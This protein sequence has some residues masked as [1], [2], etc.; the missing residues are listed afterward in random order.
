MARRYMLFPALLLAVLSA[1]AGQS[2]TL[3]ADLESPF[4][5]EEWHVSPDQ[6]GSPSLSL[7]SPVRG[8]EVPSEAG[9]PSYYTFTLSAEIDVPSLWKG[10][11]LYFLTGRMADGHSEYLLN[12]WS[13]TATACARRT[14][15]SRAG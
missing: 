1:L 13:F 14:S 7:P 2:V 6:N 10:K 9:G 15:A 3:P 4:I 11:D 5:L 12:G 8:R